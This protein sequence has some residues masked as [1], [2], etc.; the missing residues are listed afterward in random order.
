V[1][2]MVLTMLFFVRESVQDVPWLSSTLSYVAYI[3]LYLNSAR[4][5]ITPRLLIVHLAAAAF[6][7][8]LSIKVLEARKWS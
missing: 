7:L 2:M 1:V 3:E 8:F 5:S 4:G 6:W